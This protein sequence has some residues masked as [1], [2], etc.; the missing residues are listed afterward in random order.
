MAPRPAPHPEPE[1]L[2]P[3]PP[4]EFEILIAVADRA[5]HGYAIMKEVARRS[6]G[7]VRLGPG[8]LYGAIKR[9]LAS[10]LVEESDERPSDG[11]AA[12]ERRRYY[13]ITVLGR[14]VAAA[15]ARRMEQL[16]SAARAK[17]LVG[18]PEPA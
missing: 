4:S 14:R 17:R 1:S 13:R 6:D 10:G 3:L 7:A 16:V 9:M 15:E 18:R 8:T 5:R 12:D 11:T 2:L